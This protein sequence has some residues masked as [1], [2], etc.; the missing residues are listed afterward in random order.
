MID[1]NKKGCKNL[2][3]AHVFIQNFIKIIA[4]QQKNTTALGRKRI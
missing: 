4:L 3:C 1:L 2:S